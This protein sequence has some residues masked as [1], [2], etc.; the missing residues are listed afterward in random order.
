MLYRV[1]T[2]L[3][4]VTHFAF[5]IFALAGAFLVLR[6]RWVAW[7]HLPVVAWAALIEFAGWVCPLTPLENWLRVRGGA[8]GYHGGFVEH[9]IIPILYPGQLTRSAQIALG[10]LVLLINAGIYG[11][12][13]NVTKLRKQRSGSDRP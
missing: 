8:M 11:V 12:I 7:V 10:A 9:Y 4:V 6:W 3:V 2:D 13:P 1:L 5:V